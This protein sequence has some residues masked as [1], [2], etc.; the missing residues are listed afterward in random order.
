[1]AKERTLQTRLQAVMVEGQLTIA[2]LSHWFGRSY[3][4]V[5]QWALE[6]LH[7][8]QNKIFVPQQATAVYE[9]LALLEYAVSEGALKP[10][11]E[12]P[13]RNRPAKVQ[14]LHAYWHRYRRDL[15]A[16]RPARQR[17]KGRSGL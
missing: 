7:P 4:T 17:T 12:T 11:Q 6:G 8:R 3:H 9:A 1:M 10:L 16:R 2:D 5:R 13:P 15:P 14:E